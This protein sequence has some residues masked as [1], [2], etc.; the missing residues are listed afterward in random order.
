MD[1]SKTV[2]LPKTPFPMKA[3]LPH[4]E[5]AFQKFWEEIRVYEKLATRDAPKGTFVL[6]DGPPYSNG[7]IHIGH[8]L[9]KILKD[10]IV[11]YKAVSYTHL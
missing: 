4:R 2:N 3:D 7:D 8:A 10:F 6:H 9:N 1:Y 11:R 5:P